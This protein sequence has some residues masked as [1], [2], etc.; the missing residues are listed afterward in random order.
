MASNFQN[1]STV[2]ESI[3]IPET[4]STMWAVSESI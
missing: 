4:M 2:S 1:C 3:Y